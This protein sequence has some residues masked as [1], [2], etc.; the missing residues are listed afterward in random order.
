MHQPIPSDSELND[1]RD[2]D[3]DD[4]SLDETNTQT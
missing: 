1:N 2:D 4:E 3:D